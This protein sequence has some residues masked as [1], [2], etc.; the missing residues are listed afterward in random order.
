VGRRAPQFGA[1]HT[2]GD[3]TADRRRWRDGLRDFER[4]NYLRAAE[5]WAACRR[6]GTEGARAEAFFRAALATRRPREAVQLL[7]QAVALAPADGVYR[8]HLALALW[9]ARQPEAAVAELRRARADLPPDSPV[10]A[11]A[12]EVARVLDPEEQGPDGEGAAW[13]ARLLRALPE[14]EAAAA[15]D[16]RR[17]AEQSAPWPDWLALALRAAAA[18]AEGR[19]AEAAEAARAVQQADGVPPAARSLAAHWSLLAQAGLGHWGTVLRSEPAEDRFAATAAALRRA[20]AGAILAQALRA[21]DPAMAQVGLRAVQARGRLAPELATRVEAW[22]GLA[23]ARRGDWEGA[24]RHWGQARLLQPLAVASERAGQPA[25]RSAECW[26]RVLELRR[27]PGGRPLTPGEI[28]IL[29]DHLSQLWQQAG[30]GAAALRAAEV[31]L[32]QEGART[33]QRCRRVAW[34]LRRAPAERRDWR[35][36]AELL[37]EALGAEPED[38]DGWAELSLALRR[39]ARPEEAAQASWRAL[40]QAGEPAEERAKGWVEDAGAAVLAAW[41][42]AD[43]ARATAWVERLRAAAPDLP[44]EARRWAET[45]AKLAEAVLVADTHV[46]SR[47]PRGPRLQ[48]R[49]GQ[50]APVSAYIFKGILALLADG[51]SLDNRY[52]HAV[53]RYLPSGEE[54]GRSELLPAPVYLR[55]IAYAHCWA[56]Q[57]RVGAWRLVRCAQTEDC[58]LFLHWL[59]L[60]SLSPPQ[61]PSPAEPPALLRGCPEVGRLYAAWRRGEPKARQELDALLSEEDG[62]DAWDDILDGAERL[63]DIMGAWAQHTQRQVGGGGG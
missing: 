53:W 32:A 45:T 61:E 58:R 27:G 29:A 26:E 38:G 15:E 41:A 12:S 48:G 25:A 10:A 24:A 49:P 43:A 54:E 34:L 46:G 11:R 6:P 62:E 47:R 39:L 51:P 4:G 5:T 56:R 19:W 16:L 14:A 20:A 8:Y 63:L 57:V 18:V 23:F 55:W 1:A 60:A 44:G 28:A 31:A 42:E 40:E 21:G 35:R 50:D 22:L 30:H 33:P 37:Q 52:F 59:M 9:R 2:Q 13:Q 3:P 7:R 17:L 36:I